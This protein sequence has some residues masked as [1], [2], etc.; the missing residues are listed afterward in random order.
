MARTNLVS[1]ALATASANARKGEVLTREEY[2][3]AL[4]SDANNR[5][6]YAE[7][8]LPPDWLTTGLS[9]AGMGW[10]FGPVGALA[11]AGIAAILSKRRREGIATQAAADAETSAS[12]IEAGNKSLKR[13]EATAETDE[14]K[15]EIALLRDQYDGAVALAQNPNGQVAVE[16]FKQLLAIPGIVEQ[17]ADEIEAARLDAQQ[18][19][20][21]RLQ[22]EVTNLASLADDY[23]QESGRFIDVRNSYADIISAFDAPNGAGDVRGV[24]TF[25]K[26][27]DPGSTIMPGEL[28]LAENTGGAVER[29]RGLY[30]S[31]LEGESLTPLQ[32]TQ[33]LNEARE[34]FQNAQKS[35]REIDTRYMQR[36]RASGIRDELLG[37]LTV[38]SDPLSA[39]SYSTPDPL[40]RDQVNELP[41]GA[42]TVD[43][44]GFLTG[45][46]DYW[47]RFGKEQLSGMDG[48]T[49][50]YDPN[51]DAWYQ[52]DTQGQVFRLPA[53]PPGMS[54]TPQ[55]KTLLEGD[56][57]GDGDVSLLETMRDPELREQRRLEFQDRRL[58]N[59]GLLQPGGFFGPE[60]TPEQAARREELLRERERPT[61]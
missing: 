47:S 9:G 30:N 21:D 7:S 18:R 50:S 54:N 34:A 13:L 52:T 4:K 15:L 5:T 42:Q 27:L 48:S 1:T 22:Q 12:L 11:G 35:Q 45:I 10:L 53:P 44:Q 55:E 58:L 59:P 32:R 33:F 28:A 57:D 60:L 19:D 40:G 38:N 43:S 20:Q 56:A 3:A 2:E 46:I 24:Y 17:E 61:N 14:E 26:M 39:A 29:F 8:G 36:G 6:A 16:G 51:E 49:F 31:L 23:R 37:T 41:E 25:L